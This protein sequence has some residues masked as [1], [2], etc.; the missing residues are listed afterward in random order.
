M[1]PATWSAVGIAA[2]SLAVLALPTTP[3]MAF[4]GD[5]WI[6][7]IHHINNEGSFTSYAG[8]G[9]AGPQSSGAAAYVVKGDDDV[10]DAARGV[11]GLS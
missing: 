3:A 1:R 9:Y 7:G 8:A 5:Q 2:L 4:V 10:L 11:M 6:L